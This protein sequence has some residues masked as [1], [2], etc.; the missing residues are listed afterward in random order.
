MQGRQQRGVYEQ[1]AN[2]TLVP[3]SFTR[4]GLLESGFRRV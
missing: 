4:V 3:Q 2:L 1:V